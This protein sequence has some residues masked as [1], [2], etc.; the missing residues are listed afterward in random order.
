MPVGRRGSRRRPASSLPYSGLLFSIY[1]GAHTVCCRQRPG[2]LPQRGGCMAG[3]SREVRRLEAAWNAGNKWPKRLEWIEIQNIRGWTGQ[4]FELR[5][6]M[7]AVVGENGMGKSTVL[8]SAASCYANP[9]PGK[10]RFASDFFPDTPWDQVTAAEIRYSVREGESRTVGSVRKPTGRWRG[11]PDR[12][13]RSVSYIDLSRIQ[14]IPYRVGYSKL[15]NPA[16]TEGV[17]TEFDGERLSSLNSILGRPYSDARMSVVVGSGNRA[18][19]VTEQNGNIYSGFHQ[20]AGETTIIELLEV[21]IPRYSLVLI[22]EIESSLHPRAQRRLIRDLAEKCR[23]SEL[24]IIMTTH[25]PYILEELHEQARAQILQT[26]P[27]REIIY[28]VSPAFAMTKM[29]D[30]RQYECDVYVEDKRAAA[31]IV[32]LFAKFDKDL[33]DKCRVTPFGAAS[34]GQALG[35]MVAEKRFSTPTCVFLD[36]DQSES[37]GCLLLPGSDA[38]ERVVFEN[39]EEQQWLGLAE[40]VARD[41]PSV[42][43]ACGGAMTLSNHHDWVQHAAQALTLGG[44][45]LWQAMCSAWVEHCAKPSEANP[46]AQA[47][48]DMLQGIN[49]ADK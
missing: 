45:I 36:G 32:E 30:V 10:D 25:S 46:L 24:Q 29:D 39:L 4:R 19:P 49:Y 33:V 44:D 31:L 48:S 3:L 43:D 1:P 26:G 20:G 7:M 42:S 14:P 40:R 6:P 2:L 15:A 18:V 23:V 16:L 37:N 38:P 28:G 41:Y 27:S 35:I 9:G 12:R 5:F 22:D 8:Q 21:E 13:K 17:S 34:V 11:N 47:V